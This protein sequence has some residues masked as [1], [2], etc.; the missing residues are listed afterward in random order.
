M[1]WDNNWSK[2]DFRFLA[3]QCESDQ[4]DTVSTLIYLL[5]RLEVFQKLLLHG[6]GRMIFFLL[7]VSE[8]AQTGR[9]VFKTNHF[10]ISS[11]LIIAG[12]TFTVFFNLFVTAN[13][14][15]RNYIGNQSGIPGIRLNIS[16]WTQAKDKSL[17]EEDVNEIGVKSCLFTSHKVNGRHGH[18]NELNII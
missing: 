18:A 13:I 2:E 4:L 17:L 8:L 14:P 6:I 15:A 10:M 3:F 16:Y 12:N 11:C 1:L 5:L 9:N 7:N